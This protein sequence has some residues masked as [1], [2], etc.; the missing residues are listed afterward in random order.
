[1]KSSLT[2]SNDASPVTTSSVGLTTFKETS[3]DIQIDD[4]EFQNRPISNP[5]PEED[6]HKLLERTYLIGN[7]N[8]TN[9]TTVQRFPLIGLLL[10]SIGI[11]ALSKL[12]R[13]FRASFTV[14]F[15]MVSTPYHQ[16][17][18]IVG[19]LPCVNGSE[20]ID[21]QSVSCYNG[22]VLD[23]SKQDSCTF[24]TGYYSPEDWMDFKTITNSSGEHAT[25]YFA[26]LNPLLTTSTSVP[27][28]IPVEVYATVKQMALTGA[29]SGTITEV[30][31]INVKQ[32]SNKGKSDKEAAKKDR[33]GKD[34]AVG[35]VARN[36]SQLVRKVP[37]VGTVWSPIADFLNLIFETELSKPVT[38]AATVAITPAYATDVNQAD[39]I[40]EATQ[41]SLYQNAYQKVGRKMFGMDTSFETASKIAQVPML[42]DTITFNGTT[43]TW[44]TVGVPGVSG[45][46]L[47]N[48]DYLR[49]MSS[50]FRMWRGSIKYLVYFCVP[51]FYSFR[52]RIRL[53]YSATIS[54]PAD[55]PT[56]NI[57]VKGG[58]WQEFT[59]PF[60]SP[61][62][63]YD[64]TITTD[65]LHPTIIIEQL[66]AIVGTPSPSTAVVYVNIFRSG[67]EDT[68]FAV[69]WDPTNAPDHFRTKSLR[70]EQD[71]TI[72]KQQCS[73]KDCFAKTFPTI[74]KGQSFSC[75]NHYCMSETV[76]SLNDILKRAQ[77]YPSGTLM[78]GS[79][80]ATTAHNIIANLFMFR[81]G[82]IVVRHLHLGN[83]SG[84]GNDGIFLNVASTGALN[85][86]WAPIYQAG[87]PAWQREAATIPYYC[88]TPFVASPGLYPNAMI[89][90]IHQRALPVSFRL[91]IGA[92]DTIS[93]SAGD[94]F[95]FMYLVPWANGFVAG[96]KKS[97][98]P[99]TTE[100]RKLKH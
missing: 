99:T 55:V 95:M 83:T 65:N 56:I 51:A 10:N 66:S 70:I 5:F 12:Y 21:I 35:M 38:K 18:A 25:V 69:L 8:W 44:S 72:V 28:T 86:A 92:P 34:A 22:V 40:T 15:K 39:G 74:C 91:Q 45:S 78:L 29:V 75:E 94:D 81:R 50:M 24:T 23:A 100:I 47:T 76:D 20:P 71:M 63:W 98:S 64:Q 17:S 59:I 1:M 80:G 82:S 53:Q 19:W 58:T 57:D 32:Q 37:I 27:A 90:S 7:F 36:V 33:E 60:L 2:L 42:F 84:L 52:A 3:D 6:Y 46:N 77:S 85:N 67:G 13:Y 68:Q 11:T 54:S 48:S 88:A 14:H 97:S 9:S 79:T 31:M 41:L 4:G 26:P 87:T 73:I 89:S 30:E 96:N 61:R 49:I 16:G 93:I 62:T 43:V